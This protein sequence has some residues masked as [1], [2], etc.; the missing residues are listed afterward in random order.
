ME[1]HLYSADLILKLS[2]CLGT[3]DVYN[4]GGA[5]RT[6]RTKIR[7]NTA[8]WK[9]IVSRRCPCEL[10]S[11][12]SLE[13]EDFVHV[14][15]REEKEL[16]RALRM[17]HVIYRLDQ[18]MSSRDALRVFMEITTPG[19]PA[20]HDKVI[21]P[22]TL[23]SHGVEI[24]PEKKVIENK[25]EITD[26]EGKAGEE[27]AKKPK[28]TPTKFIFKRNDGKGFHI[29]DESGDHRSQYR[30]YT[31]DRRNPQPSDIGASEAK[32]QKCRVGWDSGTKT[33]LSK[34]DYAF[35]NRILKLDIPKEDK[36]TIVK[37]RS[38]DG[39]L[40]AQVV[41]ERGNAEVNGRDADAIGNRVERELLMR[42]VFRLLPTVAR[43]PR[44]YAYTSWTLHVDLEIWFENLYFANP[45]FDSKTS[46]GLSKSTDSLESSGSAIH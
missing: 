15:I 16:E 10:W 12:V 34:D 27:T 24:I 7:K 33:I 14:A 37:K 20:P 41:A 22:G 46:V 26:G 30:F 18:P 2:D 9:A 23:L 25:A 38:A 3:K 42:N 21:I 19:L 29:W 35:I 17:Y 44:V 31:I 13:D 39:A 6:A 1:V 28:R 36:G 32:F 8:L 11:Q 43:D 40:E 5:S 4:I 45:L